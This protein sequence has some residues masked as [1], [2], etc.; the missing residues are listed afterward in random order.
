MNFS[1]L[2]NDAYAR[3]ILILTGVFALFAILLIPAYFLSLRPAKG[4]TE[5]MSRIDRP[6]F[7]PLRLCP[8]RWGDL[9]FALLAGICAAVLRMVSFLCIYLHRGVLIVMHEVLPG[10]TTSY[11][12]PCAIL[13][14][15]VYLLLRTMFDCTLPAVCVA[16]LA[17]L[18]QVGN[19]WYAAVVALT[20]LFLWLWVSL[21]AD[22][23]L[24]LRAALLLAA[25]AC[26]GLLLLSN[27]AFF[28]MLPLFVAAYIYAQIYRWRCTTHSGRGIKLALSMLF[29]FFTGVAAYIAAWVYYCVFKMDGLSSVLDVRMSVE[30]VTQGL[31]A[32]LRS[33]GVCRYPFAS[34]FV[35]D[36]ILFLLGVMSVLPILHGI[37]RWRDSQCIVL[38][39]LIP[40]FIAVWLLGGMYILVPLLSV[41]F[42]WVL[43]VIAK[44]ENSWL[45]IG[46]CVLPAAV[47]LFEHFI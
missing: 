22:S 7:E 12:L 34:V 29:L 39:A 43:S 42:G 14:I 46:Y 18:M 21:D 9:P 10:L 35:R 15:V 40:V 32:R 26:Y 8:L 5:W 45:V 41:L 2:L 6:P 37:F 27:W 11:L 44:R 1:T 47:F 31:L 38:T 20:L 25:V 23:G 16:I 28:W 19:A 13:G 36:A 30:V 24:L 4:T 17:G 33:I 3:N